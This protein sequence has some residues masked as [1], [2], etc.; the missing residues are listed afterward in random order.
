MAALPLQN[1]GRMT[2]CVSAS[3]LLT[4]GC[5]DDLYDTREMK[6]FSEGATFHIGDDAIIPYADIKADLK[7]DFDLT[8]SVKGTD[9]KPIITSKGDGAL[10]KVGVTTGYYEQEI[11]RALAAAVAVNLPT[12]AGKSEVV[13]KSEGD[14]A[15]KVTVN[16]STTYQTGQVPTIEQ[17]KG[18][19]SDKGT[20]NR[21]SPLTT[22][23]D[24]ARPLDQMDPLL[25]YGLA[26]ALVQEVALLNKALDHVEALASGSHNTYVLRLRL[27]VQPN[28]PNQPYNANVSL[29][30]FCIQ[31]RE[32]D[33]TFSPSTA[34]VKVHPLLVSDDLEATATART[35]QAITQLSLAISG[36]LGPSGFGGLFNSNTAK[37]RTL[38]GK[39]LTST[40]SVSRTSDNTVA[41]R[42][43]APRQP[44]AGYAMINRNHTV[45]VIVQAPKECV[46]LDVSA[47]ASL[48]NATTGQQ[49]PDP[50]DPVIN[51]LRAGFRRY[52]E[53]FLDN[54]SSVDAAMASV[55]RSDLVKL[56]NYVRPANEAKFLQTLKDVLGRAVGSGV[57]RSGDDP[58]GLLEQHTVGWRSLWVVFSSK[59]SHSP[60]QNMSVSLPE[61][62]SKGQPAAR[63][64]RPAPSGPLVMMRAL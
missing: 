43:G 16:N 55:T 5:G 59:L 19:H 36:M 18:L 32:G 10:P 33:V 61:V 56:A 6:S 51:D 23:P 20:S 31:T 58:Q 2:V 47:A 27:A 37:I 14:G 7:P 41:V 12:I 50:I 9:G 34:Q 46:T 21:I 11:V 4:T 60:Y 17:L 42:L 39:D 35:A 53:S 52:L 49:V 28:A 13:S 64:G 62:G 26:A 25:Q 22:A 38:L 30:F 44:T 8:K 54:K 40:L 1:L 57:G 45:S 24:K 63:I 15:P 3:V 48:R 29:G